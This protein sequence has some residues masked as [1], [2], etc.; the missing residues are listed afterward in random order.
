MFPCIHNSLVCHDESA[1][2]ITCFLLAGGKERDDINT[3]NTWALKQRCL[4]SL[5]SCLHDFFFGLFC[6]FNSKDDWTVG[7]I[8]TINK[9]IWT[10]ARC[11]TTPQNPGVIISWWRFSFSGVHVSIFQLH[12]RLFFPHGPILKEREE[13]GGERVCY[14][15]LSWRAVASYTLLHQFQSELKLPPGSPNEI[16]QSF[17][18]CTPLPRDTSSLFLPWVG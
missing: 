10:L 17:F 12:C 16:M 7:N 5:N 14:L 3:Q 6:F 8:H 4:Q 9:S 15:R 13:N 18:P 1:E 2:I 11:S